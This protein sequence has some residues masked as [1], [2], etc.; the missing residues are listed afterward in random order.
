MSNTNAPQG[1]V[2]RMHATGGIVRVS[3]VPY[4]IASGLASNIYRGSGVIPVNTNKRIDVAAAGNRLVGVFHGV[5]FV[6]G[7]SGQPVF[8][9]RWATGQT[10]VTGTIAEA[11]VFDD[12]DI[13]FGIQVSTATGLVATDIGN[14]ADLVIG[15]GSAI[16]GNSGDML[17]QSTL[18]STVGTGGQLRIEALDPTQ[19]NAFGQYAKALVRIN[20][21]YFA[22]STTAGNASTPI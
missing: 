5:S 1:L 9:P 19:D 11:E 4:Q 13:L 10:L 15:T 8:S 14:F 22:G 17:D 3:P 6:D 21:H 16:T 2:H 12:P 18:T 7:V 20:E